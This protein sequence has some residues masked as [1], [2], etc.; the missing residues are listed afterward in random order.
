MPT[1]LIVMRETIEQETEFVVTADNP[2]QAEQRVAD[3]DDEYYCINRETH[4]AL[5]NAEVVS[6]EQIY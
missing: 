3:G 6:S 4:L 2:D 5:L 1:F